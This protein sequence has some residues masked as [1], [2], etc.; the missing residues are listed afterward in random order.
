MPSKQ[1]FSTCYLHVMGM[2]G[3]VIQDYI[4][5]L[6]KEERPSM[7]TPAYEGESHGMS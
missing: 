5:L 7:G 2:P 4:F 3:S 6:E 1:A